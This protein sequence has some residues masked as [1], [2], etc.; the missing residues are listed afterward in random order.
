MDKAGS[1]Q[2]L[3]FSRDQNGLHYLPQSYLKYAFLP[4]IGIRW[5]SLLRQPQSPK[6]L[7]LPQSPKALTLPVWSGS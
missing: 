6:A 7:T 2:P 4:I 3:Q 5:M 1:K